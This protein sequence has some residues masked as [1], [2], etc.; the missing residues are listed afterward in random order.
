MRANAV[1]AA[2][3]FLRTAWRAHPREVNA[4]YEYGNAFVRSGDLEKGA[5]AYAE[6]LKANAG[7]D[8]I[9]F[10]L[11]IILKRLGRNKE[12][13][14]NLLV[15]SVI[16]PLNHT[17][18]QAL[19][20]VYLSAPDRAAVAERAAADF[21]EA[22]K[23]FPA[24]PGMWNTL[25]Y[26]N[27][28]LRKYPE[29]KAAYAGGV[30]ADPANQMLVEN[31]AGVSRQLGLK[32]DPDLAWLAAYRRL[33]AAS[34]A[35]SVSEADLKAAAALL[36]QAPQSPKARLL[37]A[38]LHYKAGRLAEAKAALE[39]LLNENDLDN[40]ARYG[41]AAIYEKEGNKPL[42]RAAWERFLQIEP[43]NTAAAQRLR[44]LQ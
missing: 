36:A 41:L 4:N 19:A 5:W 26:F 39:H 11:A 15:S 1:P 43:G 18:W 29:A 3:D 6:A 13:L 34:G 30:K 10:N 42:A 8:E 38:K 7:Y 12:A 20:E 16:N 31:L 33:E 14:D 27:T 37:L 22:V 28:L 21:S 32:D 17:T 2:V 24:D 9:Y 44:A 35:P 25:G 40:Q 23:V